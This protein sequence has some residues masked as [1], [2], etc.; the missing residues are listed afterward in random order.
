MFIFSQD[1]VSIHIFIEHDNKVCHISWAYWTTPDHLNESI[2]H[3]Y[4]H[5]YASDDAPCMDM[6][7]C[8]G[9]AT[10][11]IHDV[12]LPPVHIGLHNALWTKHVMLD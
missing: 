5:G 2:Q 11:S 1:T 10:A 3:R 12:F 9:Q 8:G 7:N 4:A 6:S